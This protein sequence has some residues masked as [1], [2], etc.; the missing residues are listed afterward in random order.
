MEDVRSARQKILGMAM[1]ARAMKGA[2]KRLAVLGLMRLRHAN[3][4]NMHGPF[5]EIAEAEI[6]R[7]AYGDEFGSE[8][9]GA[10]LKAGTST[11][12]PALLGAH[13]A[14]ALLTSQSI[15]RVLQAAWSNFPAIA[16]LAAKLSLL[17][18]NPDTAYC[19]PD[20]L[21]IA[22]GLLKR[23]PAS[24]PAPA[25]AR[26]VAAFIVER[27]DGEKTIK[28][29]KQEVFDHFGK[30]RV[31]DH[32]VWRPALRS[33]QNAGAHIRSVGTTAKA[34]RSGAQ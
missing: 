8:Y 17:S 5:E 10:W 24:R 27:A 3:L 33:A 31:P 32:N 9:W 11:D 25:H 28:E 19:V 26:D 20:S 30:D 4:P 14:T 2:S 29:L 23:P 18:D 15:A 21:R 13:C 1:A 6:F 12:W 7:V 22:L 34:S 16:D